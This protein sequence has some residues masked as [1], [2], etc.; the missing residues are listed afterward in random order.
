MF[1][2]CLS[3]GSIPQSADC[4][5]WQTM[6]ESYVPSIGLITEACRANRSTQGGES[7]RYR[8]WRQSA[9]CR[10][11]SGRG[12]VIDIAADNRTL[13]GVTDAGPA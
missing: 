13:A 9:R 1:S 5:S 3:T 10:R 7:G 12:A 11:L 6:L 2:G 4:C 8:E